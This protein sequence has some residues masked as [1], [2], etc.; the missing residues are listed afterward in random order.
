[1]ACTDGTTVAEKKAAESLTTTPSSD[2]ETTGRACISVEERVR[3]RVLT[4]VSTTKK[5]KIVL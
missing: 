2:Q 1:M 5:R 4:A 3:E